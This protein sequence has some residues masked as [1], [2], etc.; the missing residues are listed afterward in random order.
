MEIR[1]YEL[2]VGWVDYGSLVPE[3]SMGI[4]FWVEIPFF[5]FCLNHCCMRQHEKAC[6]Y[7]NDFRYKCG[8]IILFTT[9][10]TITA[11]C[12]VVVNNSICY[13]DVTLGTTAGD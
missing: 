12:V 8:M 6:E 7:N 2:V 10:T 4:I 11:V 9:T 3:P 5:M 1:R 13:S